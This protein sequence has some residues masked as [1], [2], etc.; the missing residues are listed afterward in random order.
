MIRSRVFLVVSVL[1]LLTLILS[2]LFLDLR[3]KE[4]KAYSYFQE[5]QF[6][7]LLDLFSTSDSI[8][9]ELSL[10]LLSQSISSLEKKANESV[11]QE[12][13]LRFLKEKHP[14]IKITEWETS[15][16]KYYH[17][18]DRYFLLLKIHGLHYKKALIR[19]ILNIQKVIPKEK[20]SYYLL[21]LILE[22]PRGMEESY[23]SALANLLRFSME[24]I[25]EIESNFLLECLHYLTISNSS[26]FYESY[27]TVKGENVNLRNGPGKENKEVGK[28]SHPDT[29]FCFEKDSQE[30][31][32]SGKPGVFVR[33]FYP[34]LGK[35]A[36]IFS[37][38][39]EKIPPNENLISNL[40]NRFRSKDAEEKLD[41]V[42]WLGEKIPPGFFGTYIPRSRAIDAGEI[43]FP[44][45]GNK[46]KD[47]HKI[48]KK[49]T[50]DKS[51]LEFTYLS[52]IRK[53]SVPILD[54]NIV[55]GG[56]SHLLYTITSDSESIFINRNRY[57]LDLA[58]KKQTLSLH[59]ES[60]TNGNLLASLKERNK[61]LLQNIKSEPIDL[62][63][64]TSGKYSWEI[65]LPL[66]KSPNGE[67]VVLFEIKS[68]VN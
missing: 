19:K 14:D 6:E 2:Y 43:G 17:L 49:L 4:D 65:C 66:A 5:S 53:D 55:Y 56:S 31:T 45:F 21:Q 26:V 7:K 11:S 28:V 39:L 52:E 42:N 61:G 24:P 1:A 51:Y 62:N 23:S 35:S 29:T 16:G 3:E 48:C 44:L 9:S 27:F 15:L 37:G 60:K 22:D 41:F 33:C 40:Q 54:L 57:I 20:V 18:D 38:F 25:G 10:S 63:Q 67:K 32:V 59:I 46:T 13:T 34:H 50:G 68:G 64:Y 36:W 8:E 12:S 30:E 47:Y 58:D